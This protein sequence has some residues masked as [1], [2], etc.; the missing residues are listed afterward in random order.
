M[1]LRTLIRDEGTRIDDVATHLDGLSHEERLAQAMTLGRRQQRRL[2]EVAADAPPISRQH[3]VP[4]GVP[5]LTEVIHHGKNTLPVFTRFQKRFCRPDGDPEL[6]YGYNEGFTRRFIGPGYFVAHPTAGTE[7]W[8][9]RGAV[10]VDYFMVPEHEVVAGWPRI[11][12][13][14]RGL[15]FF[16]YHKTRDF[17][18]RVS[19]HV[20]IGAAFKVER[21]LGAYFVLCREDRTDG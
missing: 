12:P 14:S 11:V 8:P 15:Q 3:F 19:A 6:T 13:N 1:P 16:V 9:E 5:P 10:V 4:D 7:G 2:W 17:M 20:S 18:R 21:P